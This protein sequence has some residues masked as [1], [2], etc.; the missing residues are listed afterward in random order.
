MARPKGRPNNATRDARKAIADFVDGNSDRLTG[1]L[2]QVSE[3]VLDP[4]GEKYLVPPNPAKAFE[5]FQSVVEYHVPKLARTETV[6]LD[7]GPVE[8]SLTVS[9]K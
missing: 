5:L 2:D 8:H 7:G 6:G 1:W 3:G 4:S 9:F